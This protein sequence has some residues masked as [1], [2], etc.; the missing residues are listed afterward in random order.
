MEQTMNEETERAVIEAVQEWENA[1]SDDETESSWESAV[2]VVSEALGRKKE[3]DVNI[4]EMLGGAVS[5]AGVFGSITGDHTGEH[6]Y[7]WKVYKAAARSGRW[8]LALALAK[9]AQEVAERDDD[10]D[11]LAL[12][13]EHVKLAGD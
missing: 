12:W 8:Q 9:Y 5:G 7:I 6:A 4:A 13:S 2:A 11:E 10:D 3:T 1:T